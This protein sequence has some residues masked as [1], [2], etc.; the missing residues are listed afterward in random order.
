MTNVVTAQ[1]ILDKAAENKKI[2]SIEVEKAVDLELDLKRLFCFDPTEATELDEASLLKNARDNVQLLFKNLYGLPSIPSTERGYCVKLPQ[3][4]IVLPREKPIPKEK[5][6]TTWEKFRRERGIKKRK[7]QKMEFDEDTRTWKR[8]Y[9]ADKANDINNTPIMVFKEG[10]DP[11]EDPWSIAA[12]EKKEKI[13]WNKN[14]QTHNLRAAV[15]DRL[16][17]AI[18]LP[19]A[20]EASSKTNFLRK[21]RNL[22]KPN[23]DKKKKKKK[24]HVDVALRLVQNSTVSMGKF[25]KKLKYE[26]EI[27]RRNE[28][29][30]PSSMNFKQGKQKNMDI[31][32]GLL[33]KSNKEKLVVNKEKL[34]NKAMQA[35]NKKI[36]KDRGGVK[37]NRRGGKGGKKGNRSGKFVSKF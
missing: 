32:S 10:S 16:P 28:K 34:G 35:K 7:R 19:S 36:Q 1:E 31:L 23:K 14:K 5:P 29:V 26:P 25:D 9:G 17:G 8:R 30:G 13:S 21:K 37:P 2:I 12:R 3:P 6:L 24:D 22:S 18:D 11:T 33:G 15:G 27:K 4:T 20:I